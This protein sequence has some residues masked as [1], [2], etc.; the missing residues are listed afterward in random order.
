VTERGMI[1]IVMGNR[2]LAIRSRCGF[3]FIG[4]LY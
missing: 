4:G 3:L 1:G 2:I